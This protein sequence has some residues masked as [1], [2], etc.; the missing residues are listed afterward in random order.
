MKELLNVI[1]SYG[2][3]SWENIDAIIQGI[4]RADSRE[5]IDA[6]LKELLL[7]EGP[8]TS[9]LVLLGT[10]LLLFYASEQDSIL[11]WLSQGPLEKALCSEE[12]SKRIVVNMVSNR[13]KLRGIIDR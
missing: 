4:Y 6:F 2:W 11:T 3:L 5:R 7:S 1:I 12:L 8:E 10:F 13:Y 9:N